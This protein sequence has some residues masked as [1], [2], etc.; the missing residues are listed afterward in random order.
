MK[1]EEATGVAARRKR[2]NVEGRGYNGE[3]KYIHDPCGT[4]TFNSI[5][6]E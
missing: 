3:L 1:R 5:F 4:P 6:M 2:E